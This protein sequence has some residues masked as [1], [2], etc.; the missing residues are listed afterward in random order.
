MFLSELPVGVFRSGGGT[1]QSIK[2]RATQVRANDDRAI[3][4]FERNSYVSALFL[5]AVLGCVKAV[6]SFLPA[7]LGCV[8]AVK[9]FLPAVSE[10][11]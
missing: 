9:L 2:L 8:K 10:R 3:C 1:L 5:P 4:Y 7:V 6:I 11:A